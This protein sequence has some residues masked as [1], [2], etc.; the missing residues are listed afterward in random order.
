MKRFSKDKRYQ[1]M[2]ECSKTGLSREMGFK[3]IGY[4]EIK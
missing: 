1:N 3:D 4:K 2:F